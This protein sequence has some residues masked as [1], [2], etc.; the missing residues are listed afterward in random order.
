MSLFYTKSEIIYGQLVFN[1]I[2]H[3]S[4]LIEHNFIYFNSLSDQMQEG[5]LFRF[6]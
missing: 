1:C 3:D 6:N 4:Y 2:K 5:T